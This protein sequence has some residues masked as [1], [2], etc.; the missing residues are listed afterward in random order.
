MTPYWFLPLPVISSSLYVDFLTLIYSF[1][2]LQQDFGQCIWRGSW[3]I[4]YICYLHE[5]S[6]TS[7]LQKVRRI[8]SIETVH[9]LIGLLITRCFFKMDFVLLCCSL[10]FMK[11]LL[12]LIICWYSK[13]QMEQKLL[14]AINSG[15]GFDLSWKKV[16]DSH[17]TKDCVLC[18][19]KEH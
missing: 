14:Y 17:P 18:V 11:L 19:L 10:A 16:N 4:A 2:F 13:E 5:S 7:S 1:P 8:F 9:I 12:R 15:A 6:Q 3:P